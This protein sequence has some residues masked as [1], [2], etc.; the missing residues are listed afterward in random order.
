[1]KTPSLAYTYFLALLSIICAVGCGRQGDQLTDIEGISA[2]EIEH[3]P[4][5]SFQELAWSPDG[6]VKIPILVPIKSRLIG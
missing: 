2:I 5:A 3:S 6:R 4:P 1:M